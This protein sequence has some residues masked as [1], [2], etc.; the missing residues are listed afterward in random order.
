[1]SQRDDIYPTHIV[2]LSTWKK[3]YELRIAIED[4]FWMENI[5]FKNMSNWKGFVVLNFHHQNNNYSFIYT[6]QS[7]IE[8]LALHS[9]AHPHPSSYRWY[10]YER[11]KEEDEIKKEMKKGNEFIPKTF[12][13]SVFPALFDLFN[14][15]DQKKEKGWLILWKSIFILYYFIIFF[16][17]MAPWL[18]ESEWFVA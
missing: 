4:M 1:M 5:T 17:V 6:E 13:F 9:T 14:S 15:L 10:L 2:V 7:P 8:P 12:L 11:K 3:I 18:A 16:G